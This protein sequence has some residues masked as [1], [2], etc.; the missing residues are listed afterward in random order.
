MRLP[1]PMRQEAFHRSPLICYKFALQVHLKCRSGR[2]AA[3]KDIDYDQIET[4]VDK[5]KQHGRMLEVTFVCPMTDHR[6]ETSKSLP[7]KGRSLARRS[8]IREL[9]F[10]LRRWLYNQFG[11]NFFTRFLGRILSGA[12]SSAAH[13]LLLQRKA[14]GHRGGLL[15]GA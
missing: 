15:Q 6:V 1:C 7:H 2:E 11:R 13:G 3:M 4:I 10:S 5:V 14:R 8:G 9:R 12:V